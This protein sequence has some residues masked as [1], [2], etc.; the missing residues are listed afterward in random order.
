[1]TELLH[2]E[3]ARSAER[4]AD[5]T[6]LI[7]G[8]RHHTFAEIDAVPAALAHTL[9]AR[10]VRRVDRVAVMADNS[11]EVVVA[12]YA[13]LKAMSVKT[14]NGPA[15]RALRLAGFV[16]REQGADEPIRFMAHAEDDDGDVNSL[17][18]DPDAWLVT[19][20]DPDLEYAKT[21]ATTSDPPSEAPGSSPATATHAR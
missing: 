19:S 4:R 2:D 21:P 5:A 20:A 6:E 17:V 10:G 14:R 11:A 16:R 3:L 18:S 1:M 12:L 13:A 8:A 9:Q 15:D 7:A